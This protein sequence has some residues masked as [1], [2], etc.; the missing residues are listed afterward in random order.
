MNYFE[1]RLCWLGTSGWRS[2]TH[3]LFV[4]SFPL[5]LMQICLIPALERDPWFKELCFNKMTA[6]HDLLRLSP[7][8]WTYSSAF[9]GTA[10]REMDELLVRGTNGI[11][12]CPVEGWE[13]W[14]QPAPKAQHNSWPVWAEGWCCGSVKCDATQVSQLPLKDKIR[15]LLPAVVERWRNVGSEFQR[16][17]KTVELIKNQ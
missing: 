17:L 9:A 11:P 7:F 14:N 3:F 13:K 12:H 16:Q 15:F 8:S 5:C 10:G 1:G 4:V 2:R 6:P